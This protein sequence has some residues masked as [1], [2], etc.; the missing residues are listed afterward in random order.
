MKKSIWKLAICISV[1]LLSFGFSACGDDDD[2][3]GSK[4]D[5]IGLWEITHVKGWGTHNGAKETFDV[6]VDNMRIQ[7]NEDGTSVY[8]EK[9]GNSWRKTDTETYEYKGGRLYLYND[10]GLSYES[11]FAEWRIKVT[12]LN[13]TTLVTEQYEKEE[14]GDELFEVRTHKRIN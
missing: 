10:D 5:L 7:F 8:Y 14:D 1:T 11:D 9:S 4:E 13:S 6:N 12:T 2:E 3:V